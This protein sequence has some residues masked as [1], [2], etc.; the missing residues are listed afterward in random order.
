MLAQVCHTNTGVMTMQDTVHTSIVNNAHT[1]NTVT[2]G[3]ASPRLATTGTGPSA[4]RLGLWLLGMGLAVAGHAATPMVA[5]GF[6]HSAVLMSNG[7][8]FT[9][10]QNVQ[11]QVGNATFAKSSTLK[12]FPSQALITDVVQISIGDE[13]TTTLALKKDGTAWIWGYLSSAVNSKDKAYQSYEPVQIPNLT[14][15]TQVS[16]GLGFGIALK[17]DGTVW[18]WGTGS[19][20]QLGDGTTPSG[21]IANYTPRQVSGLAGMKLV[22]AC[23]AHALAIKSDGTVWAWGDNNIGQLGQDTRQADRSTAVQVVGISD[24]TDLTCGP[25]FSAAVRSDGTVF[26]W[27]NNI[28]YQYGNGTQA[29]TPGY[30]PTQVPGLSGVKQIA[31]AQSTL[32][33]LKTDGSV[34]AWGTNNRGQT[35]TGKATTSDSNVKVPTQVSGLSGITHVARGYH[36]S[37]AVRNDGAVLAWGWNDNGQLGDNQPSE[38]NADL[39]RYTAV[40]PLGIGGGGSLNA[41]SSDFLSFPVSAA[42]EGLPSS[43][44]LALYFSPNAADKGKSMKLYLAALLP[45]GA[46]FIGTP[47]G[48]SSFNGTLSEFATV[49]LATSFVNVFT[50]AIDVS[51]LKGT[52]LILGYGSDANEMLAAG[53][54]SVVYTFP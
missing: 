42:Y 50:T 33:A 48:F 31:G 7:T 3:R 44:T 32:L 22:R 25:N 30:A 46:L 41:N 1:A 53:R 54:I 26:V 52:K 21:Q 43:Q 20:G 18:S 35:G 11:G 13:E 9:W 15:L 4:S 27:G 10:G 45:N 34:W 16:A 49:T 6:Y 23:K 8:V 51:A 38:G 14:G 40:Q 19:Q 36:H 37:L 28:N 47:R 24:A 2:Q 39:I 17:S 29:D 12:S 5:G